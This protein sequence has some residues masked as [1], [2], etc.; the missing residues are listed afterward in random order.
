MP[1]RK[2]RMLFAAIGMAVFGEPAA[3]LEAPTGQAVLTI[4]GQIYA[5]NADDRAVF[6]MEMLRQLGAESLTTHTPWTVGPQEFVGVPMRVLLE[7]VGADGDVLIA[8]AL[9]DYHA[10]IPITDFY[11]FPVLLAY[12]NNGSPM[13]VR[14][15]GPLWIVYP[16]DDEPEQGDPENRHKWVWQLNVIEVLR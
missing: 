9:N 11:D 5:T 2:L 14:D 4:S 16:W 10:E 7:A 12:S 1:V 6:D 13:S 15:K 8:R 3:A